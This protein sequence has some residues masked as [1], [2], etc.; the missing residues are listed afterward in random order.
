MMRPRARA[1]ADT[2][3]DTALVQLLAEQGEHDEAAGI[4]ASGAG[5]HSVSLAHVEPALRRARAFALLGA[6]LAERDEWHKARGLWQDVADD[7][8]SDAHETRDAVTKVIELT[9]LAPPAGRASLVEIALWLVRHDRDAAFELL[10]DDDV[11]DAELRELVRRMREIDPE[12]ADVFVEKAAAGHGAA[13]HGGGAAKEL[14]A[15]L[16]ASYIARVGAD[17]DPDL[18]ARRVLLVC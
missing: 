11:N 12:A 10:L 9:R 8:L 5:R 7:A 15:E 2:V 4:L 14:E 1:H 6:V 13:G 18:G 3:V 16:V 17:P